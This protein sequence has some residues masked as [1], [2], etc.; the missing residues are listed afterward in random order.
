[1]ITIDGPAGA[2]KS[3]IARM[4]AERLG[5]LYIDTGAMYRALTAWALRQG[6]DVRDRTGLGELAARACVR[7]MRDEAGRTRVLVDGWDA[8]DE[9]RSPAVEASV[10]LV[11]QVPEVRRAMV[12]AQRDLAGR[13]GAVLEGRDTGTI[14]APDADRK[15]F[16]TAE[17]GT[18]ARRR[19]EQ[20][21]REGREVSLDEVERE[22]RERDRLDRE[23]EHAPLRPA[24]NAILIDTTGLEPEQVAELIIALCGCRSGVQAGR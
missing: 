10:S 2:G 21:R 1:M 8:T 19:Y 9:L 3:T 11:A 15:F 13:G 20:M 4:V 7:L 17:A 5:L 12:A 22:L 6:V 24:D 18:R 23:R 16:L 14:V